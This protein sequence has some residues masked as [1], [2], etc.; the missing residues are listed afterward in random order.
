MRSTRRRIW[1]TVGSRQ[2]VVGALRDVLSGGCLGYETCA[3]A[4][5]REAHISMSSFFA[6]G[7]GWV[8][9][10]QNGNW[11]WSGT[12]SGRWSSYD[13]RP[14]GCDY[15]F[16]TRDMPNELPGVVEGLYLLRGAGQ[17]DAEV[18]AMIGSWWDGFSPESVE[19]AR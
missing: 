13:G 2:L 3:H 1:H 17:D 15:V 4:T 19:S 6:D 9:G 5:L 8:A 18:V 14:G 7:S 12:R 10:W 16:P 11:G